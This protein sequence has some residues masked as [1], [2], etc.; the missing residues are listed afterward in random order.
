MARW[1]AIEFLR[2]S[3]KKI[4][5]NFILRVIFKICLL[6]LSDVGRFFVLI[7]DF[8]GGCLFRGVKIFNYLKISNTAKIV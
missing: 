3:L 4:Q 7:K 5:T 8:F 6:H 1:A 2:A